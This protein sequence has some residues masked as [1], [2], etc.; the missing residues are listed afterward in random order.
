[1][2]VRK[3]QGSGGPQD[4]A[5]IQRGT[6]WM[7]MWSAFYSYFNTLWVLNKRTARML[8]YKKIS[9]FQ[10]ATNFV[11]TVTIPS[12]FTELLMDRGPDDDEEFWLWAL[13]QQILYPTYS[14]I[15][16]RDITQFFDE[17]RFGISSPVMDI[18]K[19]FGRGAKR[20]GELLFI[21]EA[22]DFNKKDISTAILFWAYILKLPGRE[23]DN[24]F[25]HF[26]DVLD[27]EDFNLWE[28][29]VKNDKND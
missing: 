12:I 20:T 22:K 13:Q 9:P 3:S 18:I 21:E 11:L 10:A 4:L 17:P 2:M 8:K 6:E 5:Q 25:K 19:T 16:L 14:V 27:G 23:V 7:K 24:M 28:F 1:M 29:L 26:T 15:G